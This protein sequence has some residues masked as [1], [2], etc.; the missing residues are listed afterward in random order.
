MFHYSRWRILGI[1]S[2]V[3]LGVILA[4]PNLLDPLGYRA[5][6]DRVGLKPMT[7]GLDLQGGSNILMEVDRK[8]LTDKV[9]QQLMGDIRAALREQKIGYSGLAKTSDGV[10]VALNKV[11]DGDLA[12]VALKKLQ[13]P[14]DA[15]ILSTG[16]VVNLFDLT[17]NGQ[18]FKF[19]IQPAGFDAKTSTA[20]KQ[21]IRVMALRINGLGTTESSI[22][23]QGKD[24]ISIQIPGLQDPERVKTLLGSTAKLTFQLLCAEQPS[25]ANAL[26]PPDCT[27][28]P[29]KEDTDALIKQKED[30]RKK[31]GLPK[32]NGEVL[33]DAEKKSLPQMWVQTSGLATVDGA[34][35]TDAQPSFDQNN[36]P[37]VTFKFNQKGALRFGKLTADNVGKPFAIVLDGIIQSYPNINEPILGGSGQ[38]SGHFSSEETSNLAIT[39]RSGA[40]PAKLTIVEE[41][42]VGPSLGADSIRAG[43]YASIAGLIFVMAFI[44]LPYGF[45]GIIAD[46]ALVIN[47]IMLVGVMSFFGFT[48]TLPGIAGIVLT[49]GM[50]VDSNV[51]IYER[52]REEWR[53]GKT[54][55][56]AIETGFKAALNTVIDANV[57]T[58]I[59]AFILFGVGSGPVRGFAITLAVGI[60]T[61]MFT[62]F[63]LTRLIV[64]LWVKRFRPKEINL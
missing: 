27:A 38:I 56:S 41:R 59:A 36:T 64:A 5:I 12:K 10:S 3:L 34:D 17:Q 6:A 14:L 26:P 28:M 35:L 25:G 23:Q 9:Q 54:P 46:F 57:T 20:L 29:R 52:I 33:T 53:H 30:A 60:I 45:F 15:G 47:L 31:Q 32:I 16:T 40:L 58:L 50:A 63:A 49:L 21:A 19:A 61:T 62:A 22:Q 55:I 1:L 13:Q 2:V 44:L 48:L 43:I 39:L 24:R 11:E 4:L 51:L 42:T 8:D 7:L 37:M 18:Q